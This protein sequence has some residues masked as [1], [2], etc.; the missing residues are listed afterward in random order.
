MAAAGAVVVRLPVPPVPPAGRAHVAGK[1]AAAMPPAAP[2]M[3]RW[4]VTWRLGGEGGR[5]WWS[6]WR[7][8][9][10]C[11]VQWGLCS[12]ARAAQVGARAAPARSSP[13]KHACLLHPVCLQWA[14][15]GCAPALALAAHRWALCTTHPHPPDP[16]PVGDGPTQC[17]H[18]DRATWAG[19]AGRARIM[20]GGAMHG[21]GCVAQCRGWAA[22]AASRRVWG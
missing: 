11:R 7:W 8:R 2:R 4:Q 10:R 15:P 3:F 12:R 16:H 1:R 6:R 13:A 20:Q 17:G 21:P 22:F 5:G 14:C 9:H 19:T 18:R